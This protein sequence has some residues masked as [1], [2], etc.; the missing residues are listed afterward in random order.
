M[1]R[2]P[3]PLNKIF[4]RVT[5]E[6]NSGC[7]LWLGLATETNYGTVSYNGKR[8]LAHR[9]FYEAHKGEIPKGLV[10][11]HL[12]RNTLCVNPDHLEAVTQRENSL[13]GIGPSAQFYKRDHCNYGHLFSAQNTKIRKDGSRQCITCE[14]KREKAR[15]H[16][17]RDRSRHKRGSNES[18]P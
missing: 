16:R 11:D 13:R 3:A 8:N 7:W 15:P 14:R 6:P 9:V 2:K 4:E 17:Y 18:Q 12:C 10:I 5:P 1:P